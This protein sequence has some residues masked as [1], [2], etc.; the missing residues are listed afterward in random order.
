VISPETSPSK[1]VLVRR[2]FDRL[3]RMP[4]VQVDALLLSLEAFASSE[5]GQAEP[6]TSRLWRR[7][8][9]WKAQSVP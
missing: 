4:S 6:S 3:E 2:L 5:V 8:K 1:F 9:A 7:D